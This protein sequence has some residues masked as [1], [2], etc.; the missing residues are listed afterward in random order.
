MSNV[1]PVNTKRLLFRVL[2][3][4]LLVVVAGGLGLWVGRLSVPDD[5][6]EFKGIPGGP[7]ATNKPARVKPEE[8]AT[9]LPPLYFYAGAS[10]T[11]N[12]QVVLDEIRLAAG[13]GV[14]QV[15]L[16]W[17]LDWDN[18]SDLAGV[19]ALLERVVEAN[20]RAR[21]LLHLKL[22]PTRAWAEARPTEVLKTPADAP[23]AAAPYSGLWRD[24][25]ARRAGA[26]AR[27]LQSEKLG[28]HLKG[29]LLSAL[30]DG[31]WELPEGVGPAACEVQAFRMWLK[32]LY[33]ENEA[34][35]RA[36]GDENVSIDLVDVPA[37][38][39]DVPEAQVFLALPAQQRVA[40]HRRFLS[41]STA[42]SIAA[43]MAAIKTSA[44]GAKVYAMY[45]HTFDASD[46][47]EGTL[48]MGRLLYGDLDGFA[49]PVSA[50]DRGI[51]AAGGLSGPAFSAA[52]HQKAWIIIDDTRTGVGRDSATGQIARLPGIRAEDVY[53]V[54]RRNFSL[55]LVHGLG[56]AWSDPQGEG[57]L[58]EPEQ[59][60]E[61]ERMQEIYAD[62][63]PPQKADPA[64]EDAKGSRA[65]SSEA[66]SL[67]ML[68]KAEKKKSSTPAKAKA[69]EK[70]PAPKPAEPAPKPALAK[71]ATP[72]TGELPAATNPPP[73]A[74]TPAPNDAPAAEQQP[75]PA[76]QPQVEPVPVG[77]PNN[78]KIGLAVVIDE[79]AV[80]YLAAR[81]RV[82]D[83]IT[84]PARDAAMRSGAAVR[85]CLLQDVLDDVAPPAQV[86]LFVNAFRLTDDERTRLHARLAREQACAIWCYAPGYLA[87][88]P[89]IDG[90]A[91]TV[92][93]KLVPAKGP[94]GSTFILGGR[95]LQED[96]DVGEAAPFDPLFSIEDP[97]A[98]V[99]AQYKGTQKGS[100]AVRVMPEGWTSIYVAEPTMSPPLL[101]EL[102]RVIEKRIC[103]RLTDREVY[104]TAYVGLN[105]VA[106]HAKQPGE[107]PLTFGNI[108]DVQDLFDSATGWQ[109]KESITLPLKTGE[110]RLLKLTPAP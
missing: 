35:R 90:V 24:E 5:L 27:A 95:W 32:H 70:K 88:G 75:P 51:G 103:F 1:E 13:A 6:P 31:R 92:G 44:Q 41:E 83:R 39:K 69:P 72:P 106:I 108:C 54:Q 30:K 82:R 42:D 40:D 36:W 46:G 11:E 98:D 67:V 101:R 55:A 15:I 74:D 102:L 84:M 50:G 17:T 71:E 52:L 43:V 93:M 73:V 78:F 7:R 26:L 66:E 81:A 62:L 109:Q 9:P 87:P 59:W 63:Y 56:L 91:K 2:V 97:E 25:A 45:G 58:H 34:L 48:G 110:T 18:G 10:A 53:N 14:D 20:P 99:I 3:A 96:A 89:G 19:R 12:A 23:V 29:Y 85:S 37:E 33:P 77:P 104:D 64:S 100:I 60:Q 8:L 38:P 21:V 76:E 49:G 57:W 22:D 86:Y 65:A 68:A 105:V 4:L 47:A 79:G 94:A 16:P 107:L 80:D 28:P 61:F